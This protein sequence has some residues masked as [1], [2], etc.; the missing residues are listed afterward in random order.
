M[1][2]I[3]ITNYL[4]K[5]NGISSNDSRHGWGGPNGSLY[6]KEYLEFFI[7][8]THLD[9]LKSI[10]QSSSN[11]SYHISNRKGTVKLTNWPQHPVTLCWAKFPSK[12][13]TL[14]HLSNAC[15]H[16]RAGISITH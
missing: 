9:R 16:F 5:F 8:P 12:C 1:S 15:H 13:Y 6:Q 4:P 2:G 3:L 11:V 10:V 14:S 7:D